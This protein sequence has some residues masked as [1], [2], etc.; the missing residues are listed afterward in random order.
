MEDSST[1]RVDLI[2]MYL[3]LDNSMIW[4][5]VPLF[6]VVLYLCLSTLHYRRTKIQIVEDRLL[7]GW[8]HLSEVKCRQAFLE[9]S[10]E[11]KTFIYHRAIKGGMKV[12][13]IQLF[14]RDMND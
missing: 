2:F 7:K 12:E 3:G 9:V 6:M 8:H 4:I 1:Y 5:L 10:E 14:Q 13:A 11:D